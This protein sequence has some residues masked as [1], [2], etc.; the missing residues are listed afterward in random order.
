MAPPEVPDELDCPKCG[1]PSKVLP[2]SPFRF[3]GVD[4]FQTKIVRCDNH[5]KQK[6]SVDVDTETNQ[7]VPVGGENKR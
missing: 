5:G 7:I 4:P 3:P 6:V 1:E 2:H